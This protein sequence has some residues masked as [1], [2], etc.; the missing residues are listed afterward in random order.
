MLLSGTMDDIRWYNYTI[1]Q[2]DPVVLSDMRNGK[3]LGQD[4]A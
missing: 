1:Q 3:R 2:A 4:T